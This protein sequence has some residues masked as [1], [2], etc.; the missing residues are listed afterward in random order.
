MGHRKQLKKLIRKL[1]RK[2][3]K[4]QRIRERYVELR[5]EPKTLTREE[6]DVYKDSLAREDEWRKQN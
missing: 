4:N 5:G 1:I 6:Y 3:L 2:E